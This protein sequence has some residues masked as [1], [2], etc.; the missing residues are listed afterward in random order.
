MAN[1]TNHVIKYTICAVL[2]SDN[3]MSPGSIPSRIDQNL[4][5]RE[6]FMKILVYIYNFV[7][8]TQ[9]R[10]CNNGPV[11]VSRTY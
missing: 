7:Q 11:R 3:E 10:E 4:L 1:C 8:H 6:E 5:I 9:R 2:N